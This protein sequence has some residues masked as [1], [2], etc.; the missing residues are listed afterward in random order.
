MLDAQYSSKQLAARTIY[1]CL[2]ALCNFLND[3]QQ[4]LQS[5]SV[6]YVARL[7]SMEA[8]QGRYCKLKAQHKQGKATVGCRQ[9][10]AAA[11][12]AAAGATAS[13]GLVC[14]AAPVLLTASA[15]A[16][17]G[18]T[19]EAASIAQ[20]DQ[21]QLGGGHTDGG[22]SRPLSEPGPAAVAALPAEHGTPASNMLF[23]FGHSISMAALLQQLQSNPSLGAGCESAFA[24]L[25]GDSAACFEGVGLTA[26]PASLLLTNY[27]AEVGDRAQQCLSAG[28]VRQ[29]DINL[30]ADCLAVEREVEGLLQLSGQPVLL[31]LLGGQRLQ[32]LVEG[33]M[34]CKQRLSEKQEVEGLLQ[35]SSQP[36]LLQLLGGQRLQELVEG[37]MRCKQ[38]L[39]D[40]YCSGLG[41]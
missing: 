15:A 36:V 17:A 25:L 10:A 29:Q 5:S 39:R 24:R 27:I 38:L 37:L 31:Q 34:R 3:H 21:Q 30:R 35:L 14:Y 16:A 26:I 4:A 22:N 9:G 23:V 41:G 33:L 8:A 40:T 19:A 32:E 20:L 2:L 18:G 1:N 13:A 6:G 12:V 7:S 28:A 11:A